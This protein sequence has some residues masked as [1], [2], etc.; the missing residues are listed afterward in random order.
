MYPKGIK[1]RVGVGVKKL[2]PSF[3]PFGYI[4]GGGIRG[5]IILHK[6]S[7]INSTAGERHVKGAPF[8]AAGPC[9]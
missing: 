1:G 9:T 2:A 3:M 5:I 6:L 7:R 8:S 4:K